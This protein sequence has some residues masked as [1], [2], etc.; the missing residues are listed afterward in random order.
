MKKLF[1]LLVC[2][3]LCT[4]ALCM[5]AAAQGE[6]ATVVINGTQ[7]ED[8]DAPVKLVQGRTMIPFRPVFLALGFADEDIAWDS[9]TRTIS[10]AKE[11]VTVSFTIDQKQVTVLRDGDAVTTPTD[12]APYLDPE[13]NRTYIPARYVAEALDCRV[14]WDRESRTVIIDDVNALLANNQE[15]YHL[16]DQYQAWTQRFQNRNWETTGSFTVDQNKGALVLTADT[17]TM[18]NSGSGSE[19]EGHVRVSG[20]GAAGLPSAMDITVRGDGSTGTYYFYSKTLAE[21]TAELGATNV[22]YQ[23]DYG[24]EEGIPGDSVYTDLL[25]WVDADQTGTYEDLIRRK[26]EALPLEERIRFVDGV[27]L[28]L[29]NHMGAACATDAATALWRDRVGFYVEYFRRLRHQL[30]SSTAAFEQGIMTPP[31]SAATG[32]NASLDRLLELAGRMSTAKE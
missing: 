23:M 25:E 1:A 2:T 26:L 7:L 24:V 5:P 11:D 32:A 9:G 19:L 12:V 4:A 27:L 28:R 31:S 8:S 18:V 29:G 16:M 30:A 17:F 3:L 13:T 20:S 21:Q 22:W 15:T 14:G 6:T 10:A